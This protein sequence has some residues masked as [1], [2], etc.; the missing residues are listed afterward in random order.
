MYRIDYFSSI[1]F[2]D[3]QRITDIIK[4]NCTDMDDN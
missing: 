4:Q 2:K 3:K 1:V